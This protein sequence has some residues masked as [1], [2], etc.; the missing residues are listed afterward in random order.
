ME[1]ASWSNGQA[2]SGSGPDANGLENGIEMNPNVIRTSKSFVVSEELRDPFSTS[3][4]LNASPGQDH[5][6]LRPIHV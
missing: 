4:T 1:N 2:Q 5:T 6:P 3:S